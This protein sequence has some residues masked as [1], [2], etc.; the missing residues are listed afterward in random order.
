MIRI[1]SAYLFGMFLLLCLSFVLLVG[2]FNGYFKFYNIDEYFNLIFLSSQPWILW[3]VLALPVG[4]AI[5]YS[6]YTLLFRFAFTLLL[7]VCLSSWYKPFGK[8]LGFYIF[9]KEIIFKGFNQELVSEGLGISNNELSSINT[10]IIVTKL[11]FVRDRSYYLFPNGNV[12]L[13]KNTQNTKQ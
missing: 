11:Y 1:L 5:L 12:R 7:I 9:A 3:F 4:W 8:Q 2:I 10:P 13:I 6:N